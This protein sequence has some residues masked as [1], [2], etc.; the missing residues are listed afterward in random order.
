MNEGDLRH[1]DVRVVKRREKEKK[2]GIVAKA[3]GWGARAK[4]MEL[5]I[6]L[7]L[8]FLERNSASGRSCA[9]C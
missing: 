4:F 6:L 8:L 5:K 3:V 9:I 2:E 1:V 7:V